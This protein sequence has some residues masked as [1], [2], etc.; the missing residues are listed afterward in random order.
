MVMAVTMPVIIGLVG[1][2]LDDRGFGW[3]EIAARALSL[4]H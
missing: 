4:T 2:L 3:C 1:R